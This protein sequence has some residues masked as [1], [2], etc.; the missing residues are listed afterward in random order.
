MKKKFLALIMATAM[1][2][3]LVGCGKDAETTTTETVTET[4]EEVAETTEPAAEEAVEVTPVT[5]TVWGPSEDQ[6]EASGA[7]LPTMCEQFAALHPEW[8]IT[9]EYGVCS[10]GD[11]GNLVSQDPSASGDVYFFANDQ[12]NTLIAANAIAE[13]GGEAADYV[14][15]TNSEAIVNS[16]SV[17]GSVYGV[18]FT[19]NTWFMYYNKALLTED[20]IKNLDTM[21]TKGK[22]AFP[23]TNSWYIAS[24]F[25]ANGG[26]LFGDGTDEAAGINFGGAPGVEV[27]N[28]LIDLAA[29]ANFVNDASGEG[30]TGL[31]DGS[32]AAMFSGSWDYATLKEA[33][34]DDLGI[35]Q[36]PTVT[37]NGAEKQ[38]R[39]FAGSKAI[40]VNPNAE[41][42]KAAV[43]LAKYLGGAEAQQKHYELR[44]IVPCN[45]ELLATE[46]I[47]TDALVA[48]QNATFDNTSIIQPF[49]A[50]MGNYWTPAAN[51]GTA[52]I[53]KEITKDNAEAKV[54]E[55]NTSLNTSGV[56]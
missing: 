32:I 40:A 8:D 44:N 11:A 26:T 21:L 15:N 29:N 30:I 17:D 35:A 37:I 12:I 6:D 45:T 13:L 1:I 54:E 39:S 31:A 20:D 10:E 14:R 42:P 27:A 43:E 28:Y 49:V 9:F 2:A 41:N 38:L 7:W 48:A 25:V 3:T 22:V 55:F 33:L 16:V 52:I 4:T 50:A 53:S 5:L 23:L 36:L 19:T 34:G 56:Q 18:P 51:F 24:F 46:A 47:Q